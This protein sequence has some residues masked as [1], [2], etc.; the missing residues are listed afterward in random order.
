MD[1]NPEYTERLNEDELNLAKERF[2]ECAMERWNWLV[3]GEDIEGSGGEDLYGYWIQKKP[4]T[5]LEV[6]PNGVHYGGD[7][8]IETTNLTDCFNKVF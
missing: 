6:D 5:E 4:L 7:F 1:E 2:M 8:N 3:K